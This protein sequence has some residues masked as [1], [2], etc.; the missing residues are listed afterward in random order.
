[1]VAASGCHIVLILRTIEGGA[2]APFEEKLDPY[3]GALLDVLDVLQALLKKY[4][5]GDLSLCG[6]RIADSS[7][8]TTVRQTLPWRRGAGG[9]GRR[10][11]GTIMP[12]MIR[13]VARP[14]C[15]AGAGGRYVYARRVLAMGRSP[16]VCHAS[17][18]RG[19]SA[20]AGVAEK[21]KEKD[22]GPPP[23]TSVLDRAADAL[24]APFIGSASIGPT[25][26]SASPGVSSSY[27]WAM[28]PPAMAAH[29]CIGAPWA[30]SALSGV[31]TQE[32][33][34][35]VSAAS[36]WSMAEATT[37]MQIAFMM[38]GVGAGAAGAWQVKA[39]MRA[40]MLAGGCF[41]GGGMA[42]GGLGVLLHSKLL[43]V[44]GAGFLAGT[45]IGTMYT[46]PLQALIQW[47]PDKKGLA[48]GLVICGFGGA[49]IVFTK[50]VNTLLPVYARAPEFAGPPG[51]LTPTVEAGK[52]MAD[53][54][55]QSVEVVLATA[56]DLSKL[57]YDMDLAEGYY[58]VGTGDT[59]AAMTLMTL[60]AGYFA[61]MVTSALVMRRPAPG[62]VPEGWQAAEQDTSAVEKN[63]PLNKVMSTPQFWLLSTTFAGMATGGMSM[64]AVAKPMMS[65]VFS[66]ALPG[67]VT[68][69]FGSTYLLCL[70]GANLVGRVGWAGISDMIGRRNTF[71]TFTFGSIPLYACLPTLINS[72]VTSG[73]T[74][75]LYGFVGST[76][77]A[78]TMMGGTYA[79]MPAYEADLYGTKYVGAI[80]G[81]FL[82]FGAALAGVAGPEII[83]RLRSQSEAKAVDELLT[84]VDPAQF[85]QLFSVGIDRAPE[86]IE[87]KTLTIGKL[88]SIAPEGVVDPSPFLYDSTM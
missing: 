50:I 26:G 42:L 8:A 13:A 22:E 61:T 4:R 87:S 2:N 76:V 39:G 67:T 47:F 30:W 28:V 48:S 41:F 27:R 53:I 63:V 38:Q 80:H 36:D 5:Y 20:T 21:E 72:V 32:A 24:A 49:G 3:E 43:L 11:P 68:V 15:W 46:P 71:Y 59:G 35:V 6:P 7:E 18:A 45:G 81:R 86:L 60:G 40:S 77:L 84:Q 56:V 64:F 57:A 65:E 14:R 51:S 58:I 83:M 74:L 12:G 79:I 23:S 69:A 70:S 55:G 25:T 29:L 16:A 9:A 78:T 52:L 73:S 85:E 34:F 66:G 88:M 62:Y 75:P 10:L 54:G 19:F 37:P 44:G 17:S 31:L 33:G 82:L 1:V